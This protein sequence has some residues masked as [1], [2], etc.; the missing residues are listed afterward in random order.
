VF[1]L[2]LSRGTSIQLLMAKCERRACIATVIRLTYIVQLVNANTEINEKI[3][4][5]PAP[6]VFIWTI[7]EPGIGILAACGATLRPLLQYF[8]FSGLSDSSDN[9]TSRWPQP[10]TSWHELSHIREERLKRGT[11]LGSKDDA[12]SDVA[13]CG[14]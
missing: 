10:R 6:N 12:S 11:N 9:S 1:Y 3:L 2:S 4:I 5:S 14:S 8:K 13:L 7:V